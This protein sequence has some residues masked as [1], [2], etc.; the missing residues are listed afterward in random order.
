M[1]QWNKTP[2]WTE[3]ENIMVEQATRKVGLTAEQFNKVV[4]NIQYLKNLYGL[5]KV[6]VGTVSVVYGEPGTPFD[7][8]ITHRQE[9]IDGE[10]RDY[11]D[12]KFTMSM[13]KV[14]AVCSA[15]SVPSSSPAK[16]TASQELKENKTGYTLNFDFEIPKGEVV[17]AE[18]SQSDASGVVNYS[19]VHDTDKTF[20]STGITKLNLAIP[21]TVKHGFFAGVNFNTGETPTVLNVVNNSAFALKLMKRAAPVD[22]YSFSK[23]KTVM[24]VVSC[25]GINVYVNLLEI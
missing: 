11:I 20:T 1:A 5:Y 3:L 14:T 9:T 10:L 13:A 23:N 17:D 15:K 7:V 19:L 22:G 24:V 21:S 2:A 25:D 6:E 4:E 16:V 12:M 18:C 8:E